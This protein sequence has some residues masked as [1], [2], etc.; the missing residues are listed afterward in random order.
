M[1]TNGQGAGKARIALWDNCKFLLVYLVVVG[2]MANQLVD[3]AKGVRVIFTII[4]IFHMPAFI[5]ISG[6]FSKRN[7]DE[8][9]Y[10]RIFEH[11]LLYLFYSVFMNAS[12]LVLTGVINYRLL[13]TPSAPWYAY[14]MFIFCLIT[15]FLKKLP[16]A[17][18]LGLT[19]VLGCMAGYDKEF[20]DY[21]TLSRIFVLYPFFAAGYFMDAEKLAGLAKK[22]S[23]K[24]L[25]WVGLIVFSLVCW[26]F[27]DQLYPL[28]Q[29]YTARNSFTFLDDL[30]AYGGFIRAAHYLVAALVTFCFIMA[31]PTC[32]T[33][34][35]KWGGRSM[36]VYVFHMSFIYFMQRPL[37]KDMSIIDYLGK[38]S[39]TELIIPLGLAVTLL[40]CIPFWTKFLNFF[41]HPRWRLEQGEKKRENV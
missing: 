19:L 27:V 2:H 29:L 20:G 1:S 39:L 31:V 24:I 22:K 16:P 5:F 7:I 33:F 35:T 18:L 6:L 17:Y 34:F 40:F 9:R 36:A 13:S 12:R 10:H 23:M 38:N 3:A 4:Y 41:V 8:R 28:R 30:F 25:G 26:K 11:L 32:K 15:I 37:Y 14:A 21:L